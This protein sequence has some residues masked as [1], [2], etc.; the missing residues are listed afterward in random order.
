MSPRAIL[1][2]MLAGIS[3][4]AAL[5]NP[6][7]ALDRRVT[8]VNKT[9]YTIMEFYG[10]NTGTNSWEED[11]FGRDVLPSGRSMVINFNDGTGY[12]MF[13]FKAVFDDGDVIVSEDINIC[14]IGTYTYN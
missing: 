12:C 3:L 14:E 1:P 2:A 9:G 13:D 10:S 8:I 7:A 6:A 4:A 11:I 5:A